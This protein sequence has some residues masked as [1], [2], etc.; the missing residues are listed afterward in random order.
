M[1]KLDRILDAISYVICAIVMLWFI[2]CVPITLISSMLLCSIAGDFSNG[3]CEPSW[4]VGVGWMLGGFAAILVGYLAGKPVNNKRQP[5]NQR[6]MEFKFYARPPGDP[7]KFVDYVSWCF[8]SESIFCWKWE[9]NIQ[10]RR[11]SHKVSTIPPKD[12]R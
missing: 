10:N 7:Y 12:G 2:V 8:P 3:Q 9:L 6:K 1:T 11:S 5:G 4:L